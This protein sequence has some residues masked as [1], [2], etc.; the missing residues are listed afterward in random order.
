MQTALII[1]FS[2][3]EPLLTFG[4][5]RG[6]YCR[7]RLLP[8]YVIHCLLVHRFVGINYL[9]TNCYGN[10]YHAQ[11]HR[12]LPDCCSAAGPSSS[13]SLAKRILRAKFNRSQPALPNAAAYG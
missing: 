6:E 1:N 13:A 12:G 2:S 7:A 10:R 8:Y 3:A 11:D 4:E 5:W 9:H